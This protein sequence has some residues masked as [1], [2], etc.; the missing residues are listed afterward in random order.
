[1]ASAPPPQ[2]LFWCLCHC[3]LVPVCIA[4]QLSLETTIALAL[5]CLGPLPR[6]PSSWEPFHWP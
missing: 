3:E 6:A 5:L 4:R 1:M 2:L